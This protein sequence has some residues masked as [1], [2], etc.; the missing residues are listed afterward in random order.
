MI[1]WLNYLRVRFL[2]CFFSETF[3]GTIWVPSISNKR[4]ERLNAEA[5][6]KG[7]YLRALISYGC[8]SYRS[9]QKFGKV[10]HKQYDI[11]GWK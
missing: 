10:L 1:K 8:P 2:K 7:K 11:Y 4:R 3:I 5:K 9:S 6:A